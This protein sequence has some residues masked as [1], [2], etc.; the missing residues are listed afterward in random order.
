MSAPRTPYYD[1]LL[2]I[3]RY[4]KG[5][6]FHGLHYS[7]LSSLKLHAYSDV[8]WAGNPTNRRST[9]SFCFFL[10]DSLISLRSKKQTLTARCST[11]AKYRAL[12]DTIQEILWLRWLLADMSVV[13]TDATSLYCD[14]QSAI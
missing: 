3:F 10:G 14:N 2:H 1:A 5:T 7:S 8:D 9:T 6:L 4:L 12:A 11:E 13:S